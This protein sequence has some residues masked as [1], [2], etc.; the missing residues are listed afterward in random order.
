MEREKLYFVLFEQQKGFKVD[1][2]LVDRE[3]RENA[4]SFLHLKLPIIIT[5]VR[6]SGKSTLLYIIKEKLK[7]KE[8]EY[9]YV[10]FNDERLVGFSF[11]DFQSII[12]FLNEQNYD[13][14]CY[15]FLDEIQET[16]GW[17]K[18]IDRIKEKYPILITGSN[19]KLLSKEIST[20][21]T[22]RSISI[23]L[24]PFS[25]REFLESKKVKT[26][27]WSIDLKLQARL[28]K[29][30]SQFVLSGGI[31][32]AIVDNDKRLLQENYENILYRDIIKRFNKNLEKSI[33]EISV[34]L[35]SNVSNEISIRSLSKT[36]QIS[37]LSTVKS[38][39]E[40]FEKAFLFF[41]VNKFDYSVKKQIQNP[42]KAYCVD[43]GFINEVGFSFSEDKGRILENIVFLE[44]KRSHE[45]IYY[46]SEKG[47]CDFLLRKGIKIHQAI[48]VCHQL[49]EKNKERELSGLLEAMDKFNLKEGLILTYSQEEQIT[50]GK[51]RIIVKP[52]W[53]W[54]LE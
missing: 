19:S 38:I 12:D 1:G 6:R 29:E 30:F 25:F 45:E 33:K 48:Q 46:F 4:V 8:K 23:S 21:L 20:V 26:E 34:Y 40:T 37:N 49:N 35:L 32:K 36:I 39:L 22:G 54:I 50:E 9:L 47:E 15:L 11:E 18:W 24:Y 17:E 53:K 10:N 52:V 42:R 5:G 3:I 27:N 2:M 16:N 31:P 43:T 13:K 7:L 44:L 41:F 14:G 28:R 51:K